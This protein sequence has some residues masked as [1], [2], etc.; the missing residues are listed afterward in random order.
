[1]VGVDDL[2]QGLGG[3]EGLGVGAAHL[4]QELRVG[5]ALR[6]PLGQREGQGRLARAAQPAQ[7]ADEGVAPLDG[8]QQL[9]DLPLAA[10]EI[11][12]RRGELVQGAQG[13]AGRRRVGALLRLLVQALDLLLQ[14][15]QRALQPGAA[16]GVDGRL[17]LPAGR[18]IILE[19]GLAAPFFGAANGVIGGHGRLQK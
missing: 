13:G 1:V 16:H 11:G 2:G 18:G 8:P 19:Q 4:H 15:A 14:L 3:G 7:A 6:E 5:A 12:G 9:G 17:E 10:H